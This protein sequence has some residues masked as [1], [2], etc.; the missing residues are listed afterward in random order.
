MGFL[1]EFREF[2]SKGNVI[3]LAVGVVIGA[4]FGKIVS[5]LVDD[6]ILPPI[7]IILG[8]FDL[9][10]LYVVLPNQDPTKVAALA[11]SPSLLKAKADGIAVLAYGNFIG[12]IVQFLIVAF[13][14]FLVV[15]AKNHLQPA[16]AP[17]DPTTTTCPFC[18]S[19]I[20][21][22]AKKCKACASSLD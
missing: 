19:E 14:I 7:G 22:G 16:P 18:L 11:N 17:A 4:S 13:A 9:K 2:A 8:R 20:P 3:D 5:S 15:K 10:D 21:I 1:S 12:Q 6:V